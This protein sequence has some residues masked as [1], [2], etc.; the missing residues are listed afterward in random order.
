[1]F[2]K[3]TLH[4]IFWKECK[5]SFLFTR[6]FEFHQ[7]RNIKCWSGQIFNRTKPSLGTPF[8]LMA[9][10]TVQVFERKSVQVFLPDQK[11]QK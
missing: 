8:V 7:I 6:D 10:R 5:L 3:A 2:D 11:N 1:M 9:R 4:L